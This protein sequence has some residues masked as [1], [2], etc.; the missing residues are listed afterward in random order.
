MK[1]ILFILCSVLMIG[2]QTPNEKFHSEKKSDILWNPL[3]SDF[4]PYFYECGQDKMYYYTKWTADLD[5]LET[6]SSTIKKHIKKLENEFKIFKERI[7]SQQQKLNKSPLFCIDFDQKLDSL[8]GDMIRE[9]KSNYLV[10]QPIDL[11]QK[12][13]KGEYIYEV[14]NRRLLPGKKY[15]WAFPNTGS[16]G[17]RGDIVDCGFL[18]YKGGKVLLFDRANQELK[19][20]TK[21]ITDFFPSLL[22][23]SGHIMAEIRKKKNSFDLTVLYTFI[24]LQKE[25]NDIFYL[26]D[27][28]EY[29]IRFFYP[30]NE[31][32]AKES[33]KIII[34]GEVCYERTIGF[35]DLSLTKGLFH[36]RK[37]NSKDFNWFQEKYYQE[38][39]LENISCE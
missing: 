4:S 39:K 22:N 21:I 20:E 12:K 16:E 23:R 38:T 32:D 31:A 6:Q 3:L 30:I 28:E 34:D 18:I 36:L 27:G 11:S 24:V 26:I 15:F 1:K 5:Q 13:E 35:S 9:I 10:S 29:I 17:W 25:F 2:C 33:D 7:I 19:I 8:R 14:S 37:N